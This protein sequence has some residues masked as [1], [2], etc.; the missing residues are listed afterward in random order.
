MK[1]SIA[2][3]LLR[4]LEILTLDNETFTK[5]DNCDIAEVESKVKDGD[6]QKRAGVIENMPWFRVF[7]TSWNIPQ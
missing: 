6:L 5:R 1:Q 3:V 2:P 4:G 7:I